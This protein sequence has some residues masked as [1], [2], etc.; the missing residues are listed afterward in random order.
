MTDRIRRDLVALHRRLSPEV[1]DAEMSRRAAIIFPTDAPE[2][3]AI[4]STGVI[5]ADKTGTL[6]QDRMR[7]ARRTGS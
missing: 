5:F 4:A 2:A 6:T 3:D 1:V 7:V